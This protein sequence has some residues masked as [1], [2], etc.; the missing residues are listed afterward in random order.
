MGIPTGEQ[1]R[2]ELESELAEI[3]ERLKAIG[4]KKIVLFGS[5]AR[6]E[7]WPGSDIDLLVVLDRPGRFLDRLGLVYEAMRSRV[8]VDAIAYTSDEFEELSRTRP[9][10]QTALAEGR[11]LYETDAGRST[12]TERSVRREAH[13]KPD[14][15]SEG[16]RWLA[17]AEDDLRAAR[18][19]AQASHHNLACFQ[20]QQCAEKALKGMLYAAG[21]REVLGHA[22]GD[23]AERIRQS[24]P[25]FDDLAGKAQA[26][27]KFYIP[28]RY[29]NALPGGIPA[30][31]YTPGE[32]ARALADAEAILEAC[33]AAL[34][35]R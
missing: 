17:Q 22:A 24:R 7:V 1:R 30:Q 18:V 23:L 8:G 29:P 13:L 9:F 6:G 35:A 10:V 12:G 20:A 34:E 14:P 21:E 32:S 19:L 25:D 5:L 11:V 15:R 4:A 31:S 3:V 16:R 26:L 2:A 28:T 27:D 33:R